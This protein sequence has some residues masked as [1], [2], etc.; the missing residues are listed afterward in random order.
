MQE[1]K[2]SKS[3]LRDSLIRV[4]T[5]LVM[6]ISVILSMLA[7]ELYRRDMIEQ[8]RN[9]AEDAIDYL[10]RCVDGDDLESCMRSGQKSE[11]Y[12]ELQV[13]ADNFK[14][15]HDLVYIYIVKPL[16]KEPPDNMMDV[17]AARS[18]HEKADGPDGLTEL[19]RLTG[20]TYSFEM[21]E[22]YMARM[23]QDAK[24]TFF[25]NTTDFGNTYTAI[26]P[27]FNSNGEPIAVLCGDIKMNEIYDSVIGLAA[28]ASLTMLAYAAFVL[29]LMNRWFAYRIVTPI[30]R[31]QYSAGVVAERCR[32]RIDVSELL[33][34]DPEIHTG[35]EIEAL[36]VS[37]AAM[38]ENVRDYACALVA[39]DEQIHSMQIH[40]SEMDELAYRDALTG[41]GN[42]AAYEKEV[43]RLNRDI[44]S[45][46]PRFA[47]VMADLNYLKKV[48]DTYGH[49]RGNEYLKKMYVMIKEIFRESNVYRI[50]GDEFL[51]VVQGREMEHCDELIGRIQDNMRLTREDDNSQPWEQMSTA[52][53]SAFFRRGADTDAE[54]VFRRADAAMYENKKRMHAA[55]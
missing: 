34:D 31:L 21:T 48:N 3:S 43:E 45:G 42:K 41:A 7:F 51:I 27:I 23:D 29:I 44:L 18:S 36:S 16:K 2:V 30:T 8:Y 10:A 22:E 12:E 53:G 6:S 19:G 11:K 13:L 39:K 37:I 14:E 26:R 35:D 4:T 38:V 17:F 24:I 32:N 47:L 46:N 15:S 28:I 49:D 25:R 52:F 33:M 20:N 55:R 9:Y 1:M 40:V 50:G 54:A 5:A